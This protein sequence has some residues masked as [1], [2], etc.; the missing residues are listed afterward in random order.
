MEK[1]CKITPT[2]I[3]PGSAY[4]D[5]S[6]YSEVVSYTVS[7]GGL[8]TEPFDSFS[9]RPSPQQ[10]KIAI[11]ATELIRVAVVPNNFCIRVKEA[12]YEVFSNQAE[13]DMTVSISIGN[14]L[15]SFTS[16]KILPSS[17]ASG[18]PL[19]QV[20]E[21]RPVATSGVPLDSISGPTNTG[22]PDNFSPYTDDI[23]GI[24]FEGDTIAFRVQ[25][26]SGLYAHGIR[27]WI[28]GWLFNAKGRTRRQ[29]LGQIARQ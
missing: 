16:G 18:S 13:Q 4:A 28:Y 8:D 27:V 17:A 24:A 12:W 1:E 19:V 26:Q 7:L 22:Y 5:Q 25:N 20:M 10:R 9:V 2:M 14:N 23:F 29:I 6:A 15:S 11:G 21:V 3:S